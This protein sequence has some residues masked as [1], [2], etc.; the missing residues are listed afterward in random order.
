MQTFLP[1]P[2]FAASA[3]VLD[4]ARLGKQRVEVW[5]LLRALTDPA[6]KGWVNHPAAKMWRGY[7]GCL[8]EYG[9]AI[10]FEWMARGYTD[11]MTPRIDP[12][13]DAGIG[14]DRPSWLGDP[15]FHAAHRSNLLRK[16]PV[17]YGQFG[18][19]E[20]PDLEYVWPVSE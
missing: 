2:D 5:Q 18:W 9:L 12:Y 19:T 17:W 1:Y 13:F 10:C 8:A 7:T 14:R 3:R 16:D 6:A 11:N 20:R 4:R 15:A